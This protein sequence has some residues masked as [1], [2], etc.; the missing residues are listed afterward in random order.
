M[1]QSDPRRLVT[2][3][4]LGPDF[5]R[6]TFGGAVRGTTPSGWVRVVVRPVELR[7][8]RH[9][10][11]AYF[12]GRKTLTKNH[13][14]ATAPLDELLA[15]GFAGVHVTTTSE[16]IDVRTSKKGKVHIGR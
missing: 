14:D 12:D 16:G 13:R 9:L 6:A 11:F 5:V 7:G 10:Q 15:L 4:V 3:A 1:T 8:E 2:D